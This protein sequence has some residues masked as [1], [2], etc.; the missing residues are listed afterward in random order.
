MNLGTFLTDSAARNPRKLAFALKHGGIA[1]EQL[2]RSTTLLAR[3]LLQQGQ[4]PGDR[5]AIH[6][7]NAIEAVKLF[8]ACFKAGLV[9]VPVNA[10]MKAPE[11]AY[12]L[13]HSKCTMYFAHP[14]LSSVAQEAT[15]GCAELHAIDTL[16][17]GLDEGDSEIELPEVEDQTPAILLYTSGTTAR[18]KVVT[19]TH[20]TLLEGAKLM[21]SSAP[22]SLQTMLLM[23]QLTY[24]SGIIVGLLPTVITGGTCI[25]VPMFDAPLVLDLIEQFECTCT[26]GL[27]SMIQLLLEEQVRKPRKVHS[28]R[29]FFAAGDCVPVSIQER[30]QSLFGIPLRESYGMTESAP[31]LANP[32]HA[33]RLGSLGKPLYGVDVRIVDPDG[34]DAPDG[35]IGEIAVRSPAN[36]VGYWDD[37]VSTRDVLRK[38]WLHS[39]DLARRA[40]NR[41]VRRHPDDRCTRIC[42]GA[43][44]LRCYPRRAERPRAAAR[45]H[46]ARHRHRSLARD[47]AAGG[48]LAWALGDSTARLGVRLYGRSGQW[49][50]HHRGSLSCQRRKKPSSGTPYSPGT[51]QTPASSSTP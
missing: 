3:R 49:Q 41:S 46:R 1:Y 40:C 48:L 35:K 30:F 27:P 20:Q 42:D 38:D 18:P 14:D 51:R 28:L 25:L 19:Q 33:I 4:K 34:N 11:I 10:R 22:D 32:A 26:F 15:R 5:I 23:T 17:E 44:D 16:P 45:E 37:P 29:T 31:S 13:Q 39:G 7:P 12:V 36:F 6:W 21:C 24:I 47:C 43:N 9:A 50:A 2:D 8:F